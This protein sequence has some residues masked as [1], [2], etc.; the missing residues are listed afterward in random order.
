LAA[1]DEDDPL[2]MTDV[3]ALPAPAAPVSFTPTY[4]RLR[5]LLRSEI[6]RGDYDSRRLPTDLEL[7]G[8]F[9]VSRHTVRQAM[10]ELAAE[11]LIRREPGRGTF[12]T[13]VHNSKYVRA[14][15]N[16]DDLMA[17]AADTTLKVL[18]NLHE[19]RDEQIARRLGLDDDV[20]AG[21]TI[22]R[23]LHARPLGCAQVYLPP[24]LADSLE[25]LSTVIDYHAS[26]IHLVQRTTNVVVAGA[27][28]DITAVR[29][30]PELARILQVGEGSPLLRIERVYH[31]RERIPVEYAISHY[32]SDRYTYRVALR[33]KSGW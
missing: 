15:G 20:V 29:A 12:A 6:E 13:G 2:A 1:E 24:A 27:D 17:L 21:M 4:A 7:S 23:F 28:Q 31:S 25:P 32:R 16:I 33:G 19:V 30:T 3:V 9:G 26:I 22:L 10:G 14:L 11:G 5:E 8:R 18:A